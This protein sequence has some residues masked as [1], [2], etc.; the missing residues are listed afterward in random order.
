MHYIN[1]GF[2]FIFIVTQNL[3]QFQGLHAHL[4][5]KLFK[6]I[7]KGKF[8]KLVEQIKEADVKVIIPV[9]KK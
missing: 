9:E 3:A 8:F 5:T 1:L 2:S 7:I 6:Q 4:E